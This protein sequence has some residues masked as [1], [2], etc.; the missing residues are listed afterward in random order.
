MSLQEKEAV[1]EH[2]GGRFSEVHAAFLVDYR[3]CT[4]HQLT[5]LRNELRPLG[6]TMHVIK[7]T[8]A[9][10]AVEGTNLEPLSEQLKGPTAVIWAEEDPVSPAKVLK[11]FGKQ[12][13]QTFQVKA[14]MVDGAVISVAE[15][16]RLAELPSKE[17]LLAQLL[18]LI[19]APARKLLQTINAPAQSLQNVLSAWKDKLEEQGK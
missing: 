9:R 10:R 6:A 7:N 14:G 5:D 17:V 11:E 8:L 1:V 18:G 4:C 3:G 2:L 12:H 13:E 16:E 19:N 15:I